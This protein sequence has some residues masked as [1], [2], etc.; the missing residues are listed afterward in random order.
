MLDTYVHFLQTC[1]NSLLSL[2]TGNT[3]RAWRTSL[4]KNAK[5]DYKIASNNKEEFINFIELHWTQHLH[6]D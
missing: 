1:V 6:D 2:D 5:Y 4:I 3:S